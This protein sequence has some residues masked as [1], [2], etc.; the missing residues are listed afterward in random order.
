MLRGPRQVIC[1]ANWPGRGQSGVL[2]TAAKKASSSL[3][4]EQCPLSCNLNTVQAQCCQRFQ[5]FRRRQKSEIFF[6]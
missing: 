3:S 4:K 6:L 5:V 1:I 2:E